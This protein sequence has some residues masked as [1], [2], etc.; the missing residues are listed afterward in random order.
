MP[1]RFRSFAARLALAAV[2]S[3]SAA[4]QLRIVAWNISNY[5]G[6]RTSAIH[7]SVYAEFEGRSMSPD[8]FVLQEF[9]SQ[10]A[11]DQFVAALNSAPGSP[12]D[13]AGAVF[14]N[15]PDTD[16]AFA[17]RTSKVQL[18]DTVVVATGGVAPNFPRNL[19]RYDVRP[20]GYE[21][22]GATIAMYSVHMKA[23][24]SSTDQQRR[25]RE[26]QTIRADAE[27]LP[28]GWSFLVGGDFNIQSSNQAAYQELV[29][30][31]FDNTGRF[32]DPI[33]TPGSWNNNGS[34]RIVHTQDP[35]GAGGMDDRH[36]QI[37]LSMSMI[38][39]GGFEY[40]GVLNGITGLPVPYST[41]TWDD[42]NHSYRSWGNDGETFDQ[43]MRTVGNT[44]VGPVI[45]QALKDM[46]VGAGHLPVFLDVRVPAKVG[47]D[48]MIDLGPVAQGSSASFDLMVFNAGD[49]GLWTEDGI[50]DLRYELVSSSGLV[51]PV[52]EFTESAGG[53]ANSHAIELDTS[54]PGA[55]MGTVTILSDDPDQPGRD[56]V[57]TAMI[58]AAC[59]GDTNGDGAVNFVDLNAVLSDFGL[60]GSGLAGDVNGDEVVNF[61]D[62]NSVLSNFGASC[63]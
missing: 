40:V 38:D 43:Q 11:V 23:G 55:F 20:V 41:S 34:F 29:G 47:S 36:D 25:L 6:G 42:P 59:E 17:Y 12:G 14:V 31:Q 19:M 48:E 57:V 27:Q 45:A 60:S 3:S 16:S 4:A 62:L 30:S 22:P 28:E 63:G 58:V 32:I 51:A 1:M 5:N 52:G 2:L 10:F 15:G 26:A 24:S 13:W 33:S 9:L 53:G 18:I 54:A 37:L 35:V 46:C 50:A 49:V 39:R 21:G 8:V 61:T 56:V 44:M 7:S